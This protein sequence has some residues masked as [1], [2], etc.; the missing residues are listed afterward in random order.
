MYIPSSTPP[1]DV[2]AVSGLHPKPDSHD[3]VL[4]IEPR[5]GLTL[6]AHKRI[7]VGDI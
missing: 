2:Q 5:T 4:D 3:T 7:Q 6:A 1:P